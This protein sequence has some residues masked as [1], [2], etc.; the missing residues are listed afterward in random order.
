VGIRQG[1]AGGGIKDDAV[2]KDGP[3][4]LA[5]YGLQRQEAQNEKKQGCR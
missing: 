5:R 1:L 4:L 2:E 3:P